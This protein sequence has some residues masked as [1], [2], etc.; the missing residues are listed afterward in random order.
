[1]YCLNSIHLCC[2]WTLSRP[3]MSSKKHRLRIWIQ[4]FT[5]KVH[6]HEIYFLTFFAETKTLWSQGPVTQDFWKS[7]LI[8]PKY[9][10]SKHFRV[11]SASNEIISSYAHPLMKWVRVWTAGIFWMM[12]LKWVVI[13]SYAEH[14]WKLVTRWLSMRGNWLLVSWACAKIGYGTLWISTRGNWLLL[15]WAYA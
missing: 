2:D 1:M 4:L 8:Q 15:G 14:A 11:C 6:K 10:T 3:Q 5:L 7:N 12:I 9:S 13:S